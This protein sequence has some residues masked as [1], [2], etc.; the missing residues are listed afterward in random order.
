[1]K[2]QVGKKVKY[3]SGDWLFYGTIT[4]VI[5][6]AICRIYRLDVG[7]MEKKDCDFSITQFEFELEAENETETE[8]SIDESKMGN[9]EDEYIEN[10][11]YVQEKDLS[12]VMPEVNTK[13]VKEQSVS[14]EKQA[15]N[16]VEV[17]V[18]KS[19]IIKERKK[20]HVKPIVL[21]TA[22]SK[23]EEYVWE[24]EQTQYIPITEPHRRKRGEAW[25]KNFE[26]FQ[27]GVKKNIV[28]TWIAQNRKLYNSGSL[29]EEKL[30]RLTE[31]NFPF[32]P[33]K[34]KPK[35]KQKIE[36]N[37]NNNYLSEAWWNHKFRQWEKGERDS[38]Q[39]WK[40]KC[41]KLYINGKLSQDKIDR[42]NKLGIL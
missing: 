11:S 37:E 4:A 33:R 40:Q 13:P 8:N 31:I 39:L 9:N 29:E 20:R 42:L 15:F 18:R 25:E 14:I 6:N 21:I 2:Y 28:Y 16:P 23:L 26:L 19:R 27:K 38:L 3:D 17:P 12:Q 41:V 10:I 5:E 35:L 36:D 24:E 30:K 22:E 34:K 32:Q 1:M 7:Q